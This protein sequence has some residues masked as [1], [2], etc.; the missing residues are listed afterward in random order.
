MPMIAITTNSSTS[1][2]AQRRENRILKT[3]RDC[4]AP[5]II[6]EG[7]ISAYD[8]GRTWLQNDRGWLN[9]N[10]G[11][12]IYLERDRNSFLRN[13]KQLAFP[14]INFTA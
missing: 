6:K 3:D 5:Q 11:P 12:V 2:N 10:M 1:V 9:A 7:S 8:L 14:Q 13:R 4:I